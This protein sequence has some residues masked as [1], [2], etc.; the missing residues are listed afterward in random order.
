MNL[1]LY[2]RITINNSLLVSQ[3]T[4]IGSVLEMSES[5]FEKSSQTK[6]WVTV[7]LREHDGAVTQAPDWYPL[8]LQK[9][10]GDVLR[11]RMELLQSKS[12]RA[13]EKG[14]RWLRLLF[15]VRVVNAKASYVKK[16]GVK[17][18]LFLPKGHAK[19]PPRAVSDPLQPL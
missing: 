8:L 12:D 9:F 14:E 10:S 18:S 16:R 7:Y 4:Y 1:S 5:M 15:L 11:Q 17:R 6:L 2:G 13:L 3:Y 19:I